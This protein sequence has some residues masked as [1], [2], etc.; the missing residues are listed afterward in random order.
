M[1]ERV[2]KRFGPFR[3]AALKRALL[4]WAKTEQV[5]CWLDSNDHGGEYDGL[6]ALGAAAELKCDYGNAFDRLGEFRKRVNDWILGYLGYDLKNELEDLESRNTDGLGFPDLYFFQPEKMIFLR[7]G[8]LHF[9]YLPAFAHEIDQ[10]MEAIKAEL[11]RERKPHKYPEGLRI[12]MR[13]FKDAYQ[14][15]VEK[16]LAHIHRGD[17]YEAN[18]CQEF[19]AENAR[20]DP[21]ETYNNLNDISRPP[22]AVFFRNNAQYVLCASPERYLRKAGQKVISQPIK[23]TAP[24]ATDPVLD[25]EY[26][27][28]LA[29]DEKER[30]ENIMI[31][32]LVRHDLSRHAV[33]GSVQVEELCGVYSFR[34][35]H[36]M[37]STVSAR[38]AETMDVV[39]LL[40]D[41]FPMG[42]MTGA[43]KIS[44]MKI[45]EALEVSKRGVYSGAIGYIKPNGDFDFNVVIRSILYNAARSYV[46]FS[47][48]SAITAKADPEREYEECLLKAR[49]M[50]EV[51]EGQKQEQ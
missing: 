3:G 48:G 11:Y 25:R 40:K 45:I 5:Q 39:T 51:L 23:G 18:F 36:Q 22:F 13:L 49:A 46:S 38:V 26:R 44:A 34:Q 29:R 24:R 12:Q 21:L 41:T 28:Q 1:T 9:H 15:R 37:I 17:I 50:R 27:L 8:D 33:R 32:D 35:V 20:I 42:S 30:A 2:V 4:Y 7:N 31:V 14:E 47:V 19:Y 16:M 6:L 43:P 10:D